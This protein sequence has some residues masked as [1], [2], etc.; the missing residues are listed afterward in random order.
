MWKNQLKT[1]GAELTADS[2]D[3]VA[4]RYRADCCDRNVRQLVNA[5]IFKFSSRV[6][7]ATE[8]AS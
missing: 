6:D 1:S 4:G 3:G 2:C 8:K 5:Q 7:N